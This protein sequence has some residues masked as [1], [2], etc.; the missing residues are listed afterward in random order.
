[1]LICNDTLSF[2]CSIPNTDT[3]AGGQCLVF[4]IFKPVSPGAV[5]DL[6]AGNTFYFFDEIVNGRLPYT[7]NTD[8]V[9]LRIEY[10]ADSTCKIRIKLTQR[11]C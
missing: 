2:E 5:K 9:G 8:L 7:D 11:S 3:A 1:M 6:F 4:D 10:N